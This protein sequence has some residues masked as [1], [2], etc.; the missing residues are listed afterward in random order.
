MV[1]LYYRPNVS[2]EVAP[3]LRV[4]CRKGLFVQRDEED[5]LKS[6][7]FCSKLRVRVSS[8][9]G[10]SEPLNMAL[11]PVGS[12]L[13]S[14]VVEPQRRL[15]IQPSTGSSA[16]SLDSVGHNEPGAR[17]VPCADSLSLPATGALWLSSSSLLPKLIA[18][19]ADSGE[20]E[21]AGRGPRSY[22]GRVRGRADRLVGTQPLLASACSKLL[23]GLAQS[24]W[25]LC[26]ESKTAFD[27]ADPT[28][29]VV[30]RHTAKP[31]G[32]AASW[33]S[34][35]EAGVR[36]LASSTPSLPGRA[37]RNGIIEYTLPE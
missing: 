28:M 29:V 4:S 25:P 7:F 3:R 6:R 35:T 5:N 34:L 18:A 30:L 1:C 22:S 31:Y 9:S 27:L 2:F 17:F 8:A 23:F 20:V 16:S 21:P 10:C 26:S 11:S 37:P 12:R 24:P 13:A 33:P 32:A 15:H 36:R 19:V 14:T